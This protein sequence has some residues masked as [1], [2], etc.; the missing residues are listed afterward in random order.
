MINIKRIAKWKPKDGNIIDNFSDLSKSPRDR[1]QAFLQSFKSGADLDV[2]FLVEHSGDL[3]QLLYEGF[4]SYHELVSTKKSKNRGRNESDVLEIYLPTLELILKY[5]PNKIYHLWHFHGIGNILREIL[6]TSTCLALHNSIQ[7]KQKGIKLV[8]LW[9]YGLSPNKIAL[10][11]TTEFDRWN[12]EFAREVFSSVVPEI[13]K[14]RTSEWNNPKDYIW[15]FQYFLQSIHENI[16]EVQWPESFLSEHLIALCRGSKTLA[17]TSIR[18]EGFRTVFNLASEIYFINIIGGNQVTEKHRHTGRQLA[19]I[20]DSNETDN[21]VNIDTSTTNYI[22]LCEYCGSKLSKKPRCC[23]TKCWCRSCKRCSSDCPFMI[24][25]EVDSHFNSR[26]RMLDDKLDDIMSLSGAVM[27][28]F[29]DQGMLILPHQAHRC[30]LLKDKENQTKTFDEK[31]DTCRIMDRVLFTDR[32]VINMMNDSFEHG[33]LA[34][35]RQDEES[36]REQLVKFKNMTLLYCNCLFNIRDCNLLRRRESQPTIPSQL[37]EFLCHSQNSEQDQKI[38]RPIK[39]FLKTVVTIVAPFLMYPDQYSSFKC[40]NKR[41]IEYEINELLELTMGLYI[42]IVQQISQADA[43][44]CYRII[45]CIIKAIYHN[46][47]LGIPTE[48]YQNQVRVL[49]VI[50]RFVGKNI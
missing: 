21:N 41:N 40:E 39:E 47:K 50:V 43:S 9:F 10:D 7:L 6:S 32:A 37:P 19:S 3:I 36:Y 11:P 33:P 35:L 28:W 42:L 27:N 26:P 34:L 23:N 12:V 49:L 5:L 29:I 44:T 16:Q 1:L 20:L 25:Q 13:S 48:T 30:C 38:E 22:G 31:V 46:Y 18:I 24:A 15:K 4:W 2:E 8:V 45:T 17:V 14:V